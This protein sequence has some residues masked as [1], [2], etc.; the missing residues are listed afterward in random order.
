LAGKNSKNAMGL[1]TK[2]VFLRKI[3]EGGQKVEEEKTNE[4]KRRKT[5][6]EG[7]G[8]TSFVNSPKGN[9]NIEKTQTFF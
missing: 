1:F 4:D 7:E 2:D 6:S 9:W 8:L 3:G 5:S